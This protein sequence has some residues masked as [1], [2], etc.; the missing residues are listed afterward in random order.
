LQY[1]YNLLFLKRHQKANAFANLLV[2]PG[3]VIEQ[4]DSD[5]KWQ[6]FFINHGYNENSF[7]SLFPHTNKR[8]EIFHRKK[9]EIP[10][11]ISL[12]ICAIRETF[13][14]CGILLCKKSNETRIS[15]VS[16][17]FNSNYK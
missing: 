16:D 9:Y 13:E 15:E 5:I 2:F 4:A 14:E 6:K 12:R 11:E 1:D 8:P 10:R 3:G 7:K 17:N